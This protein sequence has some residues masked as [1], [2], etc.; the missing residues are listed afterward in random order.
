MR[1]HGSADYAFTTSLDAR[2]I[3]DVTNEVLEEFVAHDDAIGSVY[4]T[5]SGDGEIEITLEAAGTYTELERRFETL[6]RL[7]RHSVQARELTA[8]L[9][10]ETTII[11]PA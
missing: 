11:V 2:T 5:R 8:Q 4:A 6:E 3:L 10:R 1:L 9:H 7:I